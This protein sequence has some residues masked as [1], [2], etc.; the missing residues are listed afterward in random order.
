[1]RPRLFLKIVEHA[2]MMVIMLLMPFYLQGEKSLLGRIPGW[3]I[4][5]IGA[6]SAFINLFLVKYEQ[7]PC[8][9]TFN[10]T[11]KALL[12]IRLLVGT[13]SILRQEAALEW[14]WST[15]F[16]PYW[17]SITVQG[18]LVIATGVIFINTL[19]SFFRSD[20][21]FH[22]LLGSLWG[23]LMAGGFMIATLQPIL[24]IIKIFDAGR[25]IPDKFF[26][27][28]YHDIKRLELEARWLK[29][30]EKYALEMLVEKPNEIAFLISFYPI[31]YCFA[32]VF[33][34]LIFRK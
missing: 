1:M 31:I 18:V 14:D 11:V 7:T 5:I 27:P 13:M 24:V 33:I 3:V 9:A 26:D 30:S 4:I 20:T 19:G 23:L 28:D 32:T 6:C 22:D 21:K 15:T 12:I 17:C 2:L 8:N 25:G 10:L 29:D 16:W 34:T